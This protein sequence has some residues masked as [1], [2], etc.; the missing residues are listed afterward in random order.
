[1]PNGSHS[2]VRWKTAQGAQEFWLGGPG[3]DHTLSDTSGLLIFTLSS[4]VNDVLI[5]STGGYAYFETSFQTSHNRFLVP[6]TVKPSVN[7][8]SSGS[9]GKVSPNELL[10]PLIS[11]FPIFHL[12]R[13]SSKQIPIP[14]FSLFQSPNISDTGSQ[15]LCLSLFYSIDGLSAD[16]LQVIL[17]DSKTHYNRTLAFYNDITEGVWRKSEIAY[18]Y[19]TTHKVSSANIRFNY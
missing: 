18:T 15:G 17:L 8:S 10:R 9:L 2:Q 11:K 12:S 7:S 16:S 14:D 1:M 5:I 13:E 19:A 6:I 4:S 3:R